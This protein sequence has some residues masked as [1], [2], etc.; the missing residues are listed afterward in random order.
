MASVTGGTYTQTDGS[1]SFNNSI[2]SF[3]MGKYLVTYDLW[4]K[5]YQWAVLNGYTF[6]NAGR[7]GSGGSAGNAP[8][9]AKYQ[10]V[11]YINWRDAIVWC[12]AFSQ[13]TGLNS[14]YYSDAGF[15]A[16]IKDSTN[17]AYAAVTNTT[18][19]GFDDPFVDWN[20]NGYRLPTEGEYQY[21][22][23]YINGTNWT[24]YNYASGATGDTSNT[25]ATELV[26]WYTSNCSA[27]QDVG[28][29]AANALGIYDMSG[30]V[31]E[32]CWDWNAAYPGTS[33]DY[34]GPITGYTREMR[35]GSFGNGTSGLA[36]GDRGNS[37][38]PYNTGTNYGFRFASSN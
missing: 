5:V 20:S 21:A 11:T 37:T 38:G 8:T 9:S 17:G 27:T 6:A 25:A 2:S 14:V 1:N 12:N 23:S 16:P 24:P 30:N 35:G 15:K 28:G 33:T 31:F 7:E 4:Y 22:A 26:A 34:R 18:A 32:W 3:K 29:K 36:V 13:R 10:P 19:G